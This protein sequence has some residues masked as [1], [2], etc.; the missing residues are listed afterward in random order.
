MH[1]VREIT[2]LSALAP[3]ERA[4]GDLL[5]ATLGGSFFQSYDW[6]GA[7]VADAGTSALPRVLI[8]SNASRIIGI[9][10][11]IVSTQQRGL[12]KFRVLGYPLSDWGA[13]FGPVGPDPRATLT[14]GLAHVRATPRNWDVLD[15]C[16]VDRDHGDGGATRRA[17]AQCGLPARE[18]LH[19]MTA[20]IELTGDWE[21][22]WASRKSHWRTNLRR[23]EKRLALQGDVRYVRYRPAGS[24]QGDDNPRWDLYEACVALA[25]RS[26]QAGSDSGTTLSTP[27]VAPLL[28]NIHAAAVRCGAADLNL[29]LI[30]ETPVAFAYNYHYQGY[31]YGLRM[32]YD[33]AA[34]HD[35]A[36]SVLLCRALQDSFDRGDRI[37]DLGPDY[38]DCKRPWF[39]RLV[40][41][42]RYTHFPWHS[43]RAQA[44]R[45]GRW[46][47][48]VGSACRAVPES[49]SRFKQTVGSA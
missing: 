38:L 34:G 21:K 45:L 7:R 2:E 37:Y 22:Y 33:R 11:L 27:S 36:G 47:R 3:Y 9:L 39:T 28:R 1:F 13:I 42:Y 5:A 20:Q 12:G 35:G 30:G 6:F 43:P 32:G 41:T 44:V 48:Q 10:P 40:P 26:W 15:L 46:L 19:A 14:A 49:G 25:A 4:W 29:L 17:L 31:V 8:V 18:V 23:S 16:W 24:A